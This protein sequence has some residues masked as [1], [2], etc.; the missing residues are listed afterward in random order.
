VNYSTSFP[1]ATFGGKAWD[2]NIDGVAH[3]GLFPDA[4]R[5]MEGQAGGAVM[6]NKLFDGAEAFAVMWEKSEAAGRLVA[7]PPAPGLTVTT[8]DYGTNCNLPAASRNITRF[9]AA[10][11]DGTQN[12][13]FKLDWSPW[14]G[15]DP[16]PSLCKKQLVL[17]WRCPTGS[18][19][20]TTTLH[21]STPQN[22]P[23]ACP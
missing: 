2:Y 21:V 5:D 14:G 8:A 12:C 20:S 11:C 22:F 9:A 16:S 18:T 23:L 13:H 3:I 17:K 6:V 19:K 1:Q 15:R 10:Q 4:L 7:P